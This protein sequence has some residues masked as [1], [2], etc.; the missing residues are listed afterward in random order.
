MLKGVVAMVATAILQAV[1]RQ[2]NGSPAIHRRHN[3][4]PAQFTAAQCTTHN[5]PC[6]IHRAQYTAHNIPRTIYRTQFAAAQFTVQNYSP[7]KN[8][9]SAR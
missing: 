8:K 9:K 1:A 2:K 7:P 5:S 3:S 6:T 4:S